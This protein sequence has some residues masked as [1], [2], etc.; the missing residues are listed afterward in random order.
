MT[1][2]RV[3][4]LIRNILTI[5]GGFLLGKMIFGTAIDANLWEGIIGVVMSLVGTIWSIA[6]K[7]ATIEKIQG[8]VR[9]IV[10][11]LGGILVSSGKLSAEQLELWAGVILALIPVFQGW[12]SRKKVQQLQQGHIS[13]DQLKAK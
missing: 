7:T 1:Q 9:H 4:S 3:F 2:E 6:D 12:L 10:S 8:T 13:P 5:V 11:I